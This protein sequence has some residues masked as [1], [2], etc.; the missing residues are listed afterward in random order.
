MKRSSKTIDNRADFKKGLIDAIG[1]QEAEWKRRKSKNIKHKY[2]G[3][4]KN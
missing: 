2:L 1:H 3:H 4:E